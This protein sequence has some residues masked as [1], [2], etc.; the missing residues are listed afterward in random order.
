M[1]AET[2]ER[3]LADW[4]EP[5][6]ALLSRAAQRR[7]APVYLKGPL[8]PGALR[9]RSGVRAWSRWRAEWQRATCNNFITSLPPRP[10][11]RPRLRKNWCGALTGWSAV[12][13]AALVIDDTALPKKG[14]HSV[15]VAP[16]HAG[17][18]GKRANCQ[19]LVSL[20]L[21]RNEV[22]VPFALQLFLPAAW[23]GDVARLRRAGVPDA[24][25]EAP[26]KP[27]LALAELD[28]LHT[29]GVH[30]GAVLADAGYGVSALFR[31]GL[32]ARG[33]SWAVGV[34]RH[35]KVYPAEVRMI[36]PVATGRRRR[37][38][39]IPDHLSV[40]AEDKLAA[41]ARWREIRWRTG[42]KGKL[43]AR[44]AA[45]HIRVADGPA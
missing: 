19:T 20:T 40:A 42:T 30:F 35:L 26:T 17:A 41:V 18:L 24:W 2:W 28:R 43:R 11:P 23:T 38:R 44:F 9:L 8:L 22:P 14:A 25:Q 12:R 16:Q 1:R 6:L 45:A 34:P 4:L 3:D 21:A 10:G 36:E 13:I 33:L 31:Q 37:R 5:F 29:V 15:G 27:E 32:S 7:W 39:A